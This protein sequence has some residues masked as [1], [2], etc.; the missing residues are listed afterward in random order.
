VLAAVLIAWWRGDVGLPRRTLC[1]W[2]GSVV[3]FGAGLATFN[4]LVY[5]GPFRSGYPPG[6]VTFTVSAIGSNLGLLPRHLL[7]AMPVLVLGLIALLWIGARWVALRRADG[8]T[9]AAAR[10]DLWVGLALAGTW[11]AL[12]GLYSAYTWTTDP[13]NVAIQDVRFYVPALGPI[14]LLGA[15]LVA[16]SRRRSWRGAL[17]P[18]AFTVALFALGV[19]AF[20]AMYAAYGI[21]LKGL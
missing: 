11:L 9:A 5:G 15:W 10:R 12:W 6:D 3:V 7:Q 8:G 21:P 16:R 14:A 1:W 2:L 17:A 19:W 4:D 13:T 18:A 20:H